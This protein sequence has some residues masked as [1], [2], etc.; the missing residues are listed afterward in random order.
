MIQLTNLTSEAIQEHV[1]PF[2]DEEINL[3]LRYFPTIQSWYIDV[4]YKDK[5]VN[6]VKLALGVT[7]ISNSNLPF[8]FLVFDTMNTGIDPFKRDDFESERV[9]L[10]LLEYDEIT[11]IRGFDV[12][13]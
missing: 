11:T 7:H 6:G 12:P 9:L 5:Q 13:Q 10:G 3:T 4:R 1:I 2:G 8:D